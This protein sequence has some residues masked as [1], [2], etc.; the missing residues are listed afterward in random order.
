MPSGRWSANSKSCYCPWTRYPWCE[1]MSSFRTAV[2]IPKPGSWEGV[3]IMSRRAWMKASDGPC[4]RQQLWICLWIFCQFGLMS[5]FSGFQASYQMTALT[6]CVLRTSTFWET[7]HKKFSSDSQSFVLSL[8]IK[9]ILIISIYCQLLVN[10]EW[11]K[12]FWFSITY[13]CK[14]KFSLL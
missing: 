5:C 4:P 14:K 8:A 12:T 3:I 11:L 9:A 2:V 6:M 1:W 7:W 13:L 10:F